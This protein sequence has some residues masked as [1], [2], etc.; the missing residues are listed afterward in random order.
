MSAKMNWDRVR[1]ETQTRRSGSEWI[2]SDAVG[3]TPGKEIKPSRQR[4]YVQT[5]QQSER[6]R[7]LLREGDWLQRIT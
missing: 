2:G 4:Q 6:S 5:S 1:K 3:V 7:M